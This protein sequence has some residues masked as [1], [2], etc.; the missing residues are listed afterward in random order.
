MSRII[1][2]SGIDQIHGKTYNRDRG[3]SYMRNGRQ[4][5]PTLRPPNTLPP[6]EKPIQLFVHGS[7]IPS[8]MSTNNRILLNNKL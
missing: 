8:F 6:T 4:F 1:A 5:Y 3:Y 2:S 7:T